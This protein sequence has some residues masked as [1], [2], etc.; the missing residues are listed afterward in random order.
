[1]EPWPLA[2][3]IVELP[4]GRR[5]RARGLRRPLPDGLEPE[6]GIYLVGKDPGPFPWAHRWVA[7][8]DF[9]LPRST[10]EAVDALREAHDAAAERR[11]ELACGGGV[12][13][14]GTGLAVLAILSGVPRHEAVGW[15]RAHHHPKAVETR[16][17]RRWIQR[18]ELDR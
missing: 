2:D 3:G 8:P 12:G 9:R 13:R 6:L 15:V 7:W 1:M 17:Q 14:T 10:P 11:V 4:D 5:V 16:W 18:V